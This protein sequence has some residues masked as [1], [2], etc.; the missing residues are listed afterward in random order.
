M[1]GLGNQLFQVARVLDALD[2]EAQV[3]FCNHRASAQN[4]GELV[5]FSTLGTAINDVRVRLLQRRNATCLIDTVLVSLAY[6]LP[7]FSQGIPFFGKRSNYGRDSTLAIRQSTHNFLWG[8]FQK[9]APSQQT[10]SLIRSC[11]VR[12]PKVLEDRVAAH[13]RGGDYIGSAFG[14]LS[15]SYYFAAISALNGLPSRVHLVGQQTE[16]LDLFRK[17]LQTTNGLI[18]VSYAANQSELSDFYFLLESEVVIIANS[19]FSWWAAALRS[20]DGVT[21]APSSWSPSL[22]D[23]NLPHLSHWKV[24]PSSFLEG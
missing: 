7:E 18:E 17:G 6:R 15:R 8:Y 11:L 9:D 10:I 4:I 21:I 13:F 14:V 5:N 1:G 3:I 24:V 23:F 2:G 22:T 19:T 16:S 12:L 20:P